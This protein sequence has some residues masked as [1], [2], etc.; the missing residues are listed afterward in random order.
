MAK[1]IGFEDVNISGGFWKKKQDLIRNTTI[2]SVYNRFKDTG[3]IDAFRCNWV[4]GM[5]KEPHMFWDSDVAKWMESVAYLTQ[6]RR[7]PELEEKVDELVDFIEKNQS[8]NGYFNIYYTVVEKPENRFTDRRNHELYCAGHLIE[9]AIAYKRAT[10]KDKFYNCM[11]KYADCIDKA[12]RQ[13]RTAKFYTPGHQEIEMALV[14]L[15]EESG[16]RKYLDLAK[17]FIDMRGVV[18]EKDTKMLD[19]FREGYSQEHKPVREQDSAKGHAVRMHYMLC[20][21]ADLAYEYDDKGLL[22]ACETLFDD[23][24]YKKM[25]ITGGTG[26][27]RNN[28]GF[29]DPYYLPNET[30]Y[31]ETCASV[32]MALFALRMQKLSSDSKYADIAEKEIYNGFLS[33]ISLDGKSFFYENPLEINVGFAERLLRET[34]SSPCPI[35]QRVEVFSCSCCPPNITRFIPTISQFIYTEEKGTVRV[36]QYIESEAKFSENTLI[37]KTDYP[38]DGRVEFTFGG[39]TTKVG[40]RIPQWCEKYSIILNGKPAPGSVEN[41]YY[42]LM[43]SDNDKVVL[44][45]DM[46]VRLVEA[47]P[48][49]DANAGRVA[50]MRGPVVYCVERVNNELPFEGARLSDIRI[51]ADE[52][53]ICEESEAYGVPT[54]STVGEC[55]IPTGEQS[56]YAKAYRREKIKVNLIPYF[57]FANNG[58]SDM[59]IWLLEK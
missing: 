49:V 39:K 45:F 3:R 58:E 22:G 59:R 17:Y 57:A 40:F 41:G 44:D 8:E 16:E 52:D 18:E 42:Y 9:A 23:I 10:G 53:Y 33:S 35:T 15:Y 14:R 26:A 56:L 12:F 55:R 5:P 11:K 38:N 54:I 47:D 43:L 7:E 25:Y 50:V 4:E 48:R 46:P 30:A 2:H 34:G 20:A 13:E 31:N 28:E 1:N 6:T 21:M 36:N 19:L 27:N 32:A 24:V 37:Q 29:S 51:S